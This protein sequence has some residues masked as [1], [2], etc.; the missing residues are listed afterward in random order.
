L[1]RNVEIKARVQDLSE[2][3]TNVAALAS[4]PGEIINQTDTFFVVPQGRLKV[5][6]FPDGSGELISYQR[7]NKPGPR[8]SVYTRVP[9]QDAP[10]LVGALS[11]VLVVRGV[12]VK[13]REVFLVGRTRVHLDQVERLGCFVE[14]EVVLS[15]GERVEEGQREAQALLQSLEIPSAALVAEAYVDLLEATDA[16]VAASAR[17]IIANP[18]RSSA[19]VIDSGGFVKK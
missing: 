19:S 15:Q 9:C 2:I 7:S 1:A 16:S 4:G 12:V 3:R 5:R 6:A 13:R 11:S 18:S 17:S 8:E 14:L 10:A